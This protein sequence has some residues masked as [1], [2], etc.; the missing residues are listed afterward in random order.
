M[1]SRVL[2]QRKRA[3]QPA[4]APQQPSK[5]PKMG[6]QAKAAAACVVATVMFTVASFLD[7]GGGETSAVL[8]PLAL[9]VAAAGAC[10]T[11]CVA[12]ADIYIR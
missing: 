5:R 8:E 4:P 11:V 9:I 7:G 12:C 10:V 2:R 6:C 1:T 3:P